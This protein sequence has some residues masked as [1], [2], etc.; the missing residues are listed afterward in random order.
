MLKTAGGGGDGSPESREEG[1]VLHDVKQGLISP[2]R[3]AEEYGVV[4][5]TER[6]GIDREATRLRRGGMNAPPSPL[7]DGR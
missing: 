7:P 3:A 5:D 1:K 6:G 4:I 2:A